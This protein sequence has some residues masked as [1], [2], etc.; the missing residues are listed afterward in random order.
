MLKFMQITSQ[1]DEE[2]DLPLFTFAQDVTTL[3]EADSHS[4]PVPTEIELKLLHSRYIEML[5]RYYWDRFASRCQDTPGEDLHEIKREVLAEFSIAANKSTPEVKRHVWKIDDF[6]GELESDI[7]AFV[8]GVSERLNESGAREDDGTLSASFA[9]GDGHHGQSY[10]IS[11]RIGKFIVRSRFVRWIPRKWQR[12]LRW[13]FLKAGL[14][15]FNMAQFEWGRRQSVRSAEKR[16][17]EV[18]ELSK[19]TWTLAE[20]PE[21]S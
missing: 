2:R 1:V 12:R 10:K 13:V 9:G 7:N 3:L 15:A 11:K 16:L 6:L 21:P 18:P 8:Q 14:L 19:L 5:K 20:S 17:A 4:E